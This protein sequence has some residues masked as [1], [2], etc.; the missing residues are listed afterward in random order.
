MA[1]FSC[2]TWSNA[3]YDLIKW[4]K[5]NEIYKQLK[6][7]INKWINDNSN[8]K[9]NNKYLMNQNIDYLQIKSLFSMFGLMR[10]RAQRHDDD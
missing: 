2:R 5:I 6:L 8:Y 9:V 1:H 7:K 4:L 3:L 10:L